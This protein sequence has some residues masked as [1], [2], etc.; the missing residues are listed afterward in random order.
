MRPFIFMNKP[1]VAQIRNPTQE[2][3]PVFVNR[4]SPRSMTGEEL[5]DDDLMALLE[6]Y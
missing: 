2:I 5:D 6:A 3:N 4:L 1:E